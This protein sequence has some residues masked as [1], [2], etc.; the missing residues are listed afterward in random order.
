MY[1]KREITATVVLFISQYV[2]HYE[3][4]ALNLNEMI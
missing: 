4:M 3:T 2:K 1:L